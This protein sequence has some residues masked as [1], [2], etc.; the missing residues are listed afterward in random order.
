MFRIILMLLLCVGVVGAKKNPFADALVKSIREK[1][2]LE[3]LYKI[4]GKILTTF[5]K[6]NASLSDQLHNIKIIN[7]RV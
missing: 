3:N 4:S 2:D 6:S 1:E 7:F 5:D